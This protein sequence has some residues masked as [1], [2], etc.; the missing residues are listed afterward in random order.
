MNL[1]PGTAQS[2]HFEPGDLV[3][4]KIFGEGKV[5]R[6]VGDSMYVRFTSGQL[7]KLLVDFAPVVKIS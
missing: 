5:T 3:S 1:Q 4:H 6:V 2:K 7:K